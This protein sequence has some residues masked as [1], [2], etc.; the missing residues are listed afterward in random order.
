[1]GSIAV[2]KPGA[3]MLLMGNE[4]VAR[5]AIEA[6]IGVAAA[7]PGSPTS[8]VLPAIA[9]VSKAMN[10]HAE[11]SVNEKV[12]TEVAAAG[13]FAGIRSFS[14]MKQNGVNVAAD[15]IVNLNMTGIGEAG[16]VIFVSDDPG[17]MTSGNEE[18]SR[19]L[20]KWFDNPL[21]EPSNPQEAKEMVKWAYE[22][23]EE[24]NL[25]VFVRGVT[26]ISYNRV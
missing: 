4:A 7:Y 6:G 5:G 25:M 11:W 17:A 16:M 24:V 1:M 22:V 8:E 14:V 13:S 12:A 26:Q 23:S 18:D 21:L 15:F 3:T 20:A 9:S 10:I 19:T 2:N